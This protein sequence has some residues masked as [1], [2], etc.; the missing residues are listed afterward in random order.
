MK[1]LKLILSLTLGAALA[2]ACGGAADKPT[3]N[4]AADKKAQP[5]KTETTKAS[6]SA[7]DPNVF[8]HKEG[9]VQFEVPNGW[10]AAPSGDNMTVSSADGGLQVVFWV[11]DENSF[12]DAVKDLDKELSKTIKNIKTVGKPTT[13]THNG[14]PHYG[15]SGTGEVDGNTIAWSVDVLSA[16]KPVIILSFAAP[17]LYE[18]N[19]ADYEKLINSIKK[20]S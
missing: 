5:A 20:I 15:E 2:L 10:K 8:T 7:Q 16:K 18:K 17:N 11:P 13:D 9:G 19:S 6:D 3:T 12:D 4:T 14:M 1:K